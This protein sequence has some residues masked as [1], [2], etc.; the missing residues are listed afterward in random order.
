LWL[1]KLFCTHPLGSAYEDEPCYVNLDTGPQVK[2][3]L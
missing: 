3:K 2:K 1:T